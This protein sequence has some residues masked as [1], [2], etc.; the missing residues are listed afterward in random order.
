MWLL[1][2]VLFILSATSPVSSA[3]PVTTTTVATPAPTDPCPEC[4][5]FTAPEDPNAEL[6][7]CCFGR[8]CMAAGVTEA[9]CRGVWAG[10][11][12][13]CEDCEALRPCCNPFTGE[14][15]EKFCADCFDEHGVPVAACELCEVTETVAETTGA[16]TKPPKSTPAPATHSEP[17]PASPPDGAC[18]RP[19][20]TCG[21]MTQAECHECNGVFRGDYT[22]CGEDADADGFPD[23][24]ICQRRCCT[25]TTLCAVVHNKDEC[26]QLDGVLNI[27]ATECTEGGDDVCGVSCCA[28]AKCLIAK[29]EAECVACGGTPHPEAECEDVDCGGACCDGASCSLVAEE[30]ACNGTYTGGAQCEPALCG[31]AC[32]A[33]GACTE[34]TETDCDT[35]SGVF[36]GDGTLCEDTN[37]VCLNDGACCVQGVCTMASDNA[38]CFALGGVFHGEGSLC[39]DD[40]VKCDEGACCTGKGC[41]MAPDAHTCT[42]K[43][44]AW[45]G[46]GTNCEMAAICDREAG[47]CCCK[48]ECREVCSE[49]QCTALGGRAWLGAGSACEDDEATCD[50]VTDPDGPDE[51]ACCVQ[52]SYVHDGALCSVETEAECAFHGGNF[53]GTGSTCG[54]QEGG[55][56][57]CKIV[58]GACC[59]PGEAKCHDAMTI[60]ECRDCGG[61]FAGEGVSC[62]DEYV[63]QPRHTGAC[64][65]PG[66]PCKELTHVACLRDGGRFQ[67]FETTCNSE[68]GAVCSV[69]LPCE[70]DRPNEAECTMDADCP[71][72]T[73]CL[74]KYG[75]CVVEAVR[76]ASEYSKPIGWEPAVDYILPANDPWHK[77]QAGVR[78]ARK[79]SRAQIVEDDDDTP[80]PEIGENLGPLS[81]GGNHTIGYPCVVHPSPSK[82]G[83]GVCMAPPEG[84]SLSDS[85]VSVCRQVREYECGCECEDAWLKSCAHIA[86]HIVADANNDGV[87]ASDEEGVIGAIVQLYQLTGGEYEFVSEEITK[88]GGHYAFGGIP[89]GDYKVRVTLPEGNTFG[90]D[91]KSYRK[92]SVECL[93]DGNDRKR[94]V[95]VTQR[96]WQRVNQA[97][98]LAEDIDF[99]IVPGEPSDG[100]PEDDDDDSTAPA[101]SSSSTD[102]LSTGAVVGIVLGSLFIVALCILCVV[103]ICCGTCGNQGRKCKK[104]S[105]GRKTTKGRKSYRKC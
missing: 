5:E 6:G 19:D 15:S 85:C 53:Q 52:R 47:A 61:H 67:G 49:E 71:K 35:A 50:A 38:A 56:R 103:L 78:W 74:A 36:Q 18:C 25:G 84:N 101:A 22:E 77:T 2:F 28:D 58:R 105:K 23:S 16:V 98:H 66:W 45:S 31:G 63:C 59:V 54:L 41:L 37:A 46:L 104:Y 24:G 75:T 21:E 92:V 44:G 9:H 62:S 13:A 72:D 94:S 97:N 65:K 3:R 48:D 11:D 89:G 34:G 93:E 76:I 20:G 10:V 88:Q 90:G 43:D 42:T 81:C 32:C 102:G 95:A 39:S 14:C 87:R 82:C 96:A 55:E 68:D 64:C 79:M 70:V 51:G 7:A 91:G 26:D 57:T 29:T 8:T 1:L 30:A 27:F 60:S 12:T 40:D 33:Q 69:C 4:E 99:F 17:T 80:M 100:T 83:I 86:G 73:V